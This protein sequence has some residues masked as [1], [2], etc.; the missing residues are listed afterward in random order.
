[1][2][3]QKIDEIMGECTLCP[4][5]CH[6]DRIN[7]KT[8]Y[9]GM[10]NTVRVAR[11]ALHMW[12]E[13][14]IS[15]EKGSGAVFFT[16]CGLKCCFCQNREIAI[17]KSG[18]EIS[19]DRL[20]EIFLELEEKGAANINLVTGAHFVPQ[21]ISALELARKKGM[22]LPIIY[23]SSGYEKVETLKMLEGYVD[24]YLPDF[25]YMESDLAEKFSH[26]ADYPQTA[27]KAIREMIRQT[28]PVIINEDGYILRG[29]I[30]RHL[31]LPGHT[32]NSVSVL[33]YLYHEYG[34]NIFISIMNQYTPVF[35]QEKY[36]E[37]NRKVTKR[38]YEKV[39]D[40]AV[41]LGIVNGFMQEGE[42]AKESFIPSFDYEGVEHF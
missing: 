37:L 32:K 18:L 27:K 22:S 1:M 17:G 10:D 31:I 28:G 5:N 3:K 9:C 20:G 35:K 16:G 21:I 40:A 41:K 25:K 38:E 34:D 36:T 23:N 33:E 26:A 11:A 8:G 13:P 24:V 2:T 39:L 15:G 42:T 14:C 30:V 12:E 19:V 6:S 7:K 29:T 4:R